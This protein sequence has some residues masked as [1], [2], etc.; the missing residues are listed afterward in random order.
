MPVEPGKYSAPET[1]AQAQDD[2]ARL[3]L[4]GERLVLRRGPYCRRR[5]AGEH[6]QQGN[7]CDASTVHGTVHGVPGSTS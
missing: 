7:S 5:R 3:R 4:R 1:R 6:R 2:I